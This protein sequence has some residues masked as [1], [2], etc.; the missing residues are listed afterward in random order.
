M[1]RLSFLA[2]AELGLNDRFCS[3]N[4]F[5]FGCRTDVGASV[6]FYQH[7][8]SDHLIVGVSRVLKCD[9]QGH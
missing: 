7:H 6:L 8:L 4:C 3:Y 1:T 5:R 2:S 9:G